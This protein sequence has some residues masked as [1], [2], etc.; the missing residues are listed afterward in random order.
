MGVR[1]SQP[2]SPNLNKTD[3]HL[4]EYFRNTFVLVVEQIL[5]DLAP[6]SGMSASG[7][8]ITEY[9]DSGTV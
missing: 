9:T 4:L 5:L 1:S 2:R 8:N 3:G 6:P 7:G